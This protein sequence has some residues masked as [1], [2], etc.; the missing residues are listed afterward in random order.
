VPRNKIA[1]ISHP[2]S[3]QHRMPFA[4]PSVEAFETPL[5]TQYAERYL[6]R[7]GVLNDVLRV[8]APKA[9]IRDALLVHSPYLVDTVQIMTEIGS[10]ELGEASYA[11]PDLL[12][13]VLRAV[14]GAMKSAELVVAGEAEHAFSLMRPPGHHATSSDPMGLCYFNNLAIATR[15][16][17]KNEDVNKVSILD[18]DD[19]HGNG[20]S[21]IFYSDA[22]VQFISIHEYDYDNF[23]LGYFTE[24]GYGNAKGT[25]INIPLM[26][27]SPN[28]SYETALEKVI[29]PAIGR[30]APDIIMVSAG[31][32]AHYADPVGN[33]DVDSRV[34]W[35]FGK[36]VRDMV[37]TLKAKGSVWILEGGYNPFA[38]GQSIRASLDGLAGKS[39]PKLDDQIEREMFPEITDANV[40]IIDKV[41]ETIDPF[42]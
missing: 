6:D 4:R 32:D 30:F 18:F 27:T 36:F 24:L 42:W 8:K 9:K 37:R 20:T 2:K 41:L 25:N 26:E 16:I 10:G 5:R 38:L 35:Q 1:F 21:E 17:M 13:A 39:L 12:N 40:E 11:S 7:E 33:M 28:V 15:H 3:D 22:D 19:H 14:G 34:F 23:G 29:R 31:F